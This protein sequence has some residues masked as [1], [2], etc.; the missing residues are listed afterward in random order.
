MGN[1]PIQGDNSRKR[2][3]IPHNL[4]VASRI[5]K[6]VSENATGMDGPASD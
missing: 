5:G 6:V 2:L 1:L 4:I 3:L